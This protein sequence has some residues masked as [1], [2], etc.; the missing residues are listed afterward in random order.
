MLFAAAGEGFTGGCGVERSR[1]MARTL[2]NK[3]E[4][5]ASSRQREQQRYGKT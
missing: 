4:R 2:I 3:E 5:H 1:K